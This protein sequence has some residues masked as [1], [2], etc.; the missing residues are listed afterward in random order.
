MDQIE[1]V[2]RKFSLADKQ[3]VKRISVLIKARN[4]LNLNLK[5]LQ[6]HTDIY[7]VRKG[8]I[9]I[10]FRDNKKNIPTVLIV[11]RRNDNTYNF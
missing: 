11:G 1:K 3:E 5:K 10:I 7:R 8:K 4:L 2:L 6:G 9:R